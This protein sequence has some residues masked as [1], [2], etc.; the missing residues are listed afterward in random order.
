MKNALFA[1]GSL[2]FPEVFK[3]VTGRLAGQKKARLSDWR[4]VTIRG[5]TYP[6]ALPAPGHQI[7]G[8]LWCDLGEEEFRRLDEFETADYRRVPVEVYAS[9]AVVPAQVYE[10]IDQSR[11]GNEDWSVEEFVKTHLAG[12]YGIHGRPPT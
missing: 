8:I 12:F 6:G 3:A 11:I 9:G 10:W 7:E 4:R 2:M 5:E 1:Y